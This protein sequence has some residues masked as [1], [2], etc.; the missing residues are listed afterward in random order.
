MGEP[1]GDSY[2]PLN[3]LHNLTC[4]LIKIIQFFYT[5]GLNSSQN[6]QQ[7]QIKTLNNLNDRY[8]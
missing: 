3:F 5:D 1:Q 6:I 7:L 8:F 4:L 2:V